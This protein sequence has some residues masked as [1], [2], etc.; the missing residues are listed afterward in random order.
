MTSKMPVQPKSNQIS[1]GENA[2][3]ECTATSFYLYSRYCWSIIYIWLLL[4][5][6]VIKSSGNST[7]ARKAWNLTEHQ[8]NSD[9]TL[10]HLRF[11][12]VLT[13]PGLCR[14]FTARQLT[15]FPN[16]WHLAAALRRGLTEDIMWSQY[17]SCLWAWNCRQDAWWAINEESAGCSGRSLALTSH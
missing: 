9:Q 1:Y 3:P 17:M 7:D 16:R 6:L 12:R 2:I 8:R 14:P 4:G 11:T 5:S 10:N 13:W 15:E